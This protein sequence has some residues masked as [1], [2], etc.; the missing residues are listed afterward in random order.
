MEKPLFLTNVPSFGRMQEDGV[1][2]QLRA[3]NVHLLEALSAQ[4]KVEI[5]LRDRLRHAEEAKAAVIEEAKK[6]LTEVGR[7][8][9]WASHPP[10]ASSVPM[11]R[12]F[13]AVPNVEQW[14]LQ[15]EGMCT[16]SAVSIA[17]ACGPASGGRVLR[18]T[19][20]CP[21]DEGGPTRP[22]PPANGVASRP[23]HEAS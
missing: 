17:A 6:T 14:T 8:L 1:N 10:H 13:F 3:E 20:L 11:P 7:G 5:G 18:G 23:R 2:E 9:H 19:T 22:C 4:K 12:R 15:E 21:P 16:A